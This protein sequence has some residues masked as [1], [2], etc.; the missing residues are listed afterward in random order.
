MNTESKFR[1]QLTPEAELGYL[2][3]I[4]SG[5]VANHHLV[6]Y[7]QMVKPR[8]DPADPFYDLERPDGSGELTGAALVTSLVTKLLAEL[9]AQIEA[10]VDAHPERYTNLP[11]DQM[12]IA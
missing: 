1:L 12:P 5:L 7:R 2:V 10:D 4:T 6:T 11:A 8:P 3:T 9:R